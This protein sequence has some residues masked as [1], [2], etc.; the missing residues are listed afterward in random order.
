MPCAEIWAASF[1]RG[2]GNHFDY[3]WCSILAKFL[4]LWGVLVLFQTA[5]TV[6]V[7][8]AWECR[9]APMLRTLGAALGIITLVLL[10]IWGMGTFNTLT[11]PPSMCGLT[12]WNFSYL[13]WVLVPFLVLFFACCG[14]PCLYC[15]EFMHNRQTDLELMEKAGGSWNH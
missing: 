12:L 2:G 8:A 4:Q 11:S 5:L 14:L 7:T 1:F 13:A 6:A 9:N 10:F 3:W 15:T